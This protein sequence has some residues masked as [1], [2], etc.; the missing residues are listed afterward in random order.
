[1]SILLHSVAHGT[2]LSVFLKVCLLLEFCAMKFQIYTLL[3]QEHAEI[4][5]D[6]ML[7]Y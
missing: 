1:M 6:I 4:I 3:S 7:K 5:N 2:A